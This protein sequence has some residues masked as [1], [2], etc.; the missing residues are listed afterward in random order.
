MSL[1]TIV[2]EDRIEEGEGVLKLINL[3]LIKRVI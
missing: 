1:F 3:H 2:G